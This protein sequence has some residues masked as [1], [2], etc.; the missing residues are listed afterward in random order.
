MKFW[1]FISVGRRKAFEKPSKPIRFISVVDTQKF[2]AAETLYMSGHNSKS[3]ELRQLIFPDSWNTIKS[4]G[5]RDEIRTGATQ[6][7][8]F[9]IARAWRKELEDQGVLAFVQD[10]H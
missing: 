7:E 8:A 9:E 1:V 2:L 6:E 3:R 4:I 10:D 5:I